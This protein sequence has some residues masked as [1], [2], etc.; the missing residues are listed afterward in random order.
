MTVEDVTPARKEIRNM[1]TAAGARDYA[2]AACWKD[3]SQHKKRNRA[4]LAVRSPTPSFS[5]S[6]PFPCF[7]TSRA[8]KSAAGEED[9]VITK[10][11]SEMSK[12]A[13]WAC[14]S[15]W[16]FRGALLFDGSCGSFYGGSFS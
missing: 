5:A 2:S 14:F 8:E 6:I 9:A 10:D 15:A 11:Q 1:R 3:N 13:A 7:S 16:F 12:T 4:Q